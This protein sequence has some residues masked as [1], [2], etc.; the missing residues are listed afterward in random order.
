VSVQRR[1]R[2]VD[3]FDWSCWPE[4]PA[5]SPQ[6]TDAPSV[7]GEEPRRTE[8]R[9]AGPVRAGR[10][11]PAAAIPEGGIDPPTSPAASGPL[12]RSTSAILGELSLIYRSSQRIAAASY[13]GHLRSA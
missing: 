2:G 8:F 5:E 6:A 11:C 12:L 9:L 10:Q 4:P 13:L 1:G 7:R 3:W